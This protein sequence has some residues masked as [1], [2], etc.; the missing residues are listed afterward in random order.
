MACAQH[1]GADGARACKEPVD[2]FLGARI[3]ELGHAECGA[4]HCRGL[5]V[6]GVVLFLELGE[7]PHGRN[8]SPTLRLRPANA[9]HRG[10]NGHSVA[11]R[12]RV[13]LSLNLDG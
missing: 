1:D 12:H 5:S 10:S 3:D 2:F 6:D 13:G 11:N 9:R 4:C 8:V 7:E